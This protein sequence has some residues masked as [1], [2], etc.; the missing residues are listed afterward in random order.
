MKKLLIVSICAVFAFGA[1]VSAES[2]NA[3][4]V[5]TVIEA[6]N[7]DSCIDLLEGAD[8]EIYFPLPDGSELLIS[9]GNGGDISVELGDAL[10]AKPIKCKLTNNECNDVN[11]NCEKEG[12]Q[13]T[14]DDGSIT[15][16]GAR[17]CSRVVNG[18]GNETNRCT[19]GTFSYTIPAPKP[20]DGDDD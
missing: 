9:G 1:T 14:N 17:Q 5:E 2:R 12:T 10:A 8:G 4:G 3:E 11:D 18:Q 7:S 20:V 13:T 15:V 6:L 16:T 19:C